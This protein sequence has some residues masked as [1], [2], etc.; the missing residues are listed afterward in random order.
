MSS[1]LATVSV[2][3]D[4]RAFAQDTNALEIPPMGAP[5]SNIEDQTPDT[6][7]LHSVQYTKT[8]ATPVVQINPPAK[9]NGTQPKAIAP[10]AK[11]TV[12]PAK[13]IVMAQNGQNLRNFQND[14]IAENTIGQTEQEP[15]FE[16]KI[17]AANWGGENVIGDAD[18]VLFEADEVFRE[19]DDGPITA[20]GNVNAFFG[21]RFLRADRLVYDPAT[22]IVVAEGN[23][24][25]TDEGQETAFAG[26]VQLTGDL[27]DGIV[28]NFSAILAENAK[29]AAESAVREQGA[30]TR[31][32]KAVYTACNV[33][34][35]DGDRKTP[36]WRLKSLRV[37]RD[38]ERK[39]VR[40]YHAFLEFKGLP[41]LYVPFLQGP[42]P[43][44]ER[45]SGLLAPKIGASSRLGFNLETP[46]YLAISNSQDATFSPKFTTDDGILWQGEYRNRG[47]KGY[48]VLA[49]GVI[50]FD[51]RGLNEA[52]IREDE[53][54]IPG[55]R[56]HYFGQGHRTI[57]NNWRVSYDVERV[58][59]DAYLR[60]YDVE[61][62]GDLRQELDRALTNR[63]RSNVRVEW[64]KGGHDLQIDSYLFQGLRAT[65]DETLTPF[66]LP[67]V[68]YKY[69]FAN[70]LAGGR[71]SISANSASL[72]RTEG[73]DTQ[74][75]TANAF[76]ERDVVT[77][78]GHRFNVFAEAR[79]DIYYFSDLTLSLIHI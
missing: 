23:V 66:V 46:Y 14:P 73:T 70:K 16:V 20:T 24:A 18:A 71:A 36:T 7:P 11:A 61:R 9:V 74:R 26:R 29:L 53:N 76:W 33:C 58:S 41:I 35:D 3:V 59:D 39:V 49:G 4:P 45:Q 75:F 48:H 55:V 32:N 30:R 68:D 40:F 56:W 72:I 22:N 38:E 60:R 65:D 63:L 28:E 52:G 10:P 2:S 44:V 8:N 31:L 50:D 5:S 21:T 25:I 57:G 69:R 64:K 13:T 79:G 62:E 12:L 47:S 77:R 37:V 67:R 34:D 15:A 54:G 43:S 42:D 27:R 17:P 1:A 19:I 6:I 51:N 78:G